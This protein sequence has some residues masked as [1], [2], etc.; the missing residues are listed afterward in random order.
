MVNSIKEFSGEYMLLIND[1]DVNV[2]G[3]LDNVKIKNDDVVVFV[4]I[5]HGGA[6]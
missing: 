5:V 1:V 4:P 2:Y 6:Q 3:G